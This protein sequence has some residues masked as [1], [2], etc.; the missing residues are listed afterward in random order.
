MNVRWWMMVV[1]VLMAGACRVELGAEGRPSHGVAVAENDSRPSAERTVT[2][3]LDLGPGQELAAGFH[4]GAIDVHAGGHQTPRFSAVL[5]AHAPTQSQA[6]Q[7]VSSYSLKVARSHGTT[8][9]GLH[10]EPLRVR[11]KRGTEEISPI[12][13]SF[14]ALVLPGTVLRLHSRYGP[15]D[16]SGPVGRCTLITDGGEVSVD[17]VLRDEI[18]IAARAGEV[19][20]TAAPGSRL[21]ADWSIRSQG[22][23]ILMTIPASLSCRLIATSRGG[24]VSVTGVRLSSV[25][26]EG[27]TL[28]ATLGA[29]G[30]ELHLL[31]QGGDVTIRTAGS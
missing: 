1:L 4:M 6:D 2:G 21:A 23:N 24:S 19:R 15:I 12:V 26:Q 10:G 9:I 27:N 13:K 18:R 28:R 17:G 25:N 5:S 11:V 29:G 16:V 7:L 20:V 22:G 30:H 14:R 8:T 31:A 3:T